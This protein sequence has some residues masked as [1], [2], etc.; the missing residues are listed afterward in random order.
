MDIKKNKLS[1]L[2]SLG[3]IMRFVW[4]IKPGYSLILCLLY[5]VQGIIPAYTRDI[6]PPYIS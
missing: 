5:I 4:N 6:N 1:I 2:S 3:R